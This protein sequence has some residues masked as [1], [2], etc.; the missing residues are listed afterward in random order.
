MLLGP[1]QGTRDQQ[2]QPRIVGGTEAPEGRFNFMAHLVFCDPGASYDHYSCRTGCGGSLITPDVVLSAAH[3]S[4]TQYAT[5]RY[6]YIGRHSIDTDTEYEVLEVVE[7]IPNPGYDS[8]TMDSDTMLLRLQMPSSQASVVIDDGTY[9]SAL[10]AGD[11]LNVMGWGTTSSGGSSTDVLME[12]GV[13][14]VTNMECL[15]MYSNGITASM[16]C[17]A[18]P[19]KDSCQGDSGGPLIVK[20]VD[21]SRDVQVG[22]V[23]WGYGCADPDYPGVYARTATAMSWILETLRSWGEENCLETPK[24]PTP[25]GNVP[26]NQRTTV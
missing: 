22:V 16:M 24:P 14:F 3:C 7:E 21:A 26:H 1:Y 18:R 12:T 13:D 9:T 23:S 2:I 15:T 5:I 8:L 6:V 17:A 11:D 20:G 25:T 19:G 10:A 4:S